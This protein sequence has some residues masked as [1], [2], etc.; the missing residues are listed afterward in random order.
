MNTIFKSEKDKKEFLRLFREKTMSGAVSEDVAIEKIMRDFPHFFHQPTEADIVNLSRS[1]LNAEIRQRA[2]T[3]V[4][5][6][7]LADRIFNNVLP[8]TKTS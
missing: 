4:Q 8:T 3:G 5:S 2:G 7:R 1:E 6:N